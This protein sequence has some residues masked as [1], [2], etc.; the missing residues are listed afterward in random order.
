MGKRVESFFA[1]IRLEAKR[2]GYHAELLE[3]RIAALRQRRP[4]RECSLATKR[5][6]HIR[7]QAIR[8]ELMEQEVKRLAGH[9]R[10]R[11]LAEF[12]RFQNR[13]WHGRPPAT[14]RRERG[15]VNE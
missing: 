10:W 7:A 2:F 4:R 9:E 15:K 14:S 11:E 8:L 1:R 13:I 12:A 6:D 5:L 3:E